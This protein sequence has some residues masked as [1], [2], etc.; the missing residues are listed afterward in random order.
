MAKKIG[1]SDSHPVTASYT[2]N[3]SIW[4]ANYLSL[5]WEIVS[6]VANT[7]YIRVSDIWY[8]SLCLAGHKL[9]HK[10]ISA[11]WLAI[12]F[13]TTTQ[14]LRTSVKRKCSITDTANQNSVDLTLHSF[15]DD[16]ATGF[17]NTQQIYRQNTHT[18]IYACRLCERNIEMYSTS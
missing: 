2:P 16:T 11:A 6:S 14:T 1:P 4:C 13:P 10:A 12:K 9:K 3:Q 7:C 17:L 18:Q 8:Y 15:T 5:C